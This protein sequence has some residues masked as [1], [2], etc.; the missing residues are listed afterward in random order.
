MANELYRDLGI[1]L[2]LGL[3]IGI[4]RGWSARGEPDGTRVAG[5]RTF[6][7]IGLIGGLAG[8]AVTSS[9][10]IFGVLFV[11]A[12]AIALI[13]G[14]IRDMAH[15]G[16][17]SATTTMAAL[18]T[19]A[20]GMLATTGYTV[21]ASVSAGVMLGLL[22]MREEL[23]AWVGGLSAVEVKAVARLALITVVVWPLLPDAAYGPY[24]AWN[25]R[26]LWAVVVLISGLSF[27]G[28]VANRRLG[29][30]R[31]TLATAAT[32]ALVSSTAVTV[33]LS[34]RLAEGTGPAPL[35]AGI[36]IAG[37]VMMART[38]VLTALLAGFAV[39]SLA[40]VV[41]PAGAAAVLAALWTLRKGSASA[42]PWAYADGVSLIDM[43]F[44]PVT[45]I[46]S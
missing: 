4:E 11:A 44:L 18:I 22:A 37:A 35:V 36:A 9:G 25:P 43:I 5:F 16:S 39:P 40:V 26:D 12:A 27:V 30:V 45:T 10:Q 42:S 46:S 24:D 1:A 29:D 31:G 33:A 7:L 3:L 8:I 21:I 20:L 23:H 38:L 13:A 15:G 6:G 32:G 41:V 34:R 14:Y 2:A 17:V 28:Y 19:L